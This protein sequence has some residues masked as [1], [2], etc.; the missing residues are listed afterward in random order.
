[1]HKTDNIDDGYMGSGKLIR[2]AIA[3]HGIKNFE[4]E[5]LYIFDN[6]NDM[7]IKEKEIVVVSENTY[8]LNEGGHG[9]F[10]YINSNSI[11]DKKEAGKKGGAKSKGRKAP[12]VSKRLKESQNINFKNSAKIAFLG[13][14]HNQKTKILI[15]E[16]N[17]I[18]Q[19]GLNNSQFG[20]CWITN[21]L[22]NKKIKKEELDFWISKGYSKGRVVSK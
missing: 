11:G 3:K 2:R 14:K 20:T 12:W 1:M 5:I 9:G 22:E 19:Q 18:R 8:N 6:E 13:K 17:S 15:G 16:K 21:G 4:K 10:G 7:K